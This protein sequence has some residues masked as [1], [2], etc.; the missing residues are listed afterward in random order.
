MKPYVEW[1]RAGLKQVEVR[2]REELAKAIMEAA[3][4][5]VL[6]LG[7]KMKIA[8]SDSPN[9]NLILIIPELIHYY[10]PDKK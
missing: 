4:K 5:H 10:H 3:V 6:D 2:Q 9:A 7:F 8:S 1:E